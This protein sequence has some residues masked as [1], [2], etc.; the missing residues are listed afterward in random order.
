[1]KTERTDTQYSSF[2]KKY[3]NKSENADSLPI[4]YQKLIYFS[5]Q[6]YALR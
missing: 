5:L 6:S 4:Y 2:R 1:V 3:N